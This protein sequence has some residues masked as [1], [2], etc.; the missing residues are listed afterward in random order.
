[1]TAALM[2]SSALAIAGVCTVVLLDN[3]ELQA[4]L[5]RVGIG[6]TMII[7]NVEKVLARDTLVFETAPID[8]DFSVEIEGLKSYAAGHF[9]LNSVVTEVKA[10]EVDKLAVLE[11][12]T[13]TSSL[14]V[15]RTK[16][17]NVVLFADKSVGHADYNK[18]HCTACSGIWSGTSVEE[19][20]VTARDSGTGLA[21]GRR[22]VGTGLATGR[23]SKTYQQQ[24]DSDIASRKLKGKVVTAGDSGLLR[25]WMEGFSETSEK[26]LVVVYEKMGLE[27]LQ[28][29]Q[30][31]HRVKVKFPTL[32]GEERS[33]DFAIKENGIKLAIQG[34]QV[35][36][37]M[38]VTSITK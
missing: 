19:S 28:S 24:T 8:S 17:G 32:N 26:E 11:K 33:A 37:R 3:E 27:A 4:E 15:M 31:A 36:V 20:I 7:K 34:S 2:F 12:D 5:E 16:D 35:T 14:T 6:H 10:H 29:I 1:M 18:I 22:D 13:I 38:A 23:K 30:N 25:T 21:T 9:I